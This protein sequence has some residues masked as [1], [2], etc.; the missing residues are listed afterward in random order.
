MIKF[1]T[2]KKIVLTWVLI[3]LLFLSVITLGVV[4]N[5]KNDRISKQ[6]AQLE[7][8]QK[9][10]EEYSKTTKEIKEAQSKIQAELEAAKEKNSQ[11]EKKID[12][13]TKENK[14]IKKKLNTSSQSNSSKKVLPLKNKT[15]TSTSNNKLNALTKSLTLK[16]TA[17]KPMANK[18]CYLTFDDGPSKNTTKILDILKKNKVKA[19]FFVIGT[20]NL[21]LLPR[22]KKE[23][24][25]IGLHSNS[26]DYKKI[27]SSPTAFLNDL[28]AI[29][30]KVEKKIGIKVNIIRFPGGSDNLVSK[31]YKKGIMKDLTK[32]LP[33]M[34]YSYFDWNVVSGDAD[35]ALMPTKNIINQSVNGAKNKKSVC[36][37]MHD[38]SAK[39]TTV[40]ALPTI[41]KKY[42]AMGFKFDVITAETYGFHNKVNN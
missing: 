4:I 6:S 8:A 16:K 1:I 25:A 22:I 33:K 37:L 30:K 42:K 36:L 39:T 32:R 29:S 38:A 41:I 7:S 14:K 21:D 19:T 3:A 18:V 12:D 24:H 9:T 28:S 40:N 17:Q 5:N 13:L 2:S 11:L 15:K 20:G 34:G 10:I 27:Y 31:K 26:H 23:G 35:R